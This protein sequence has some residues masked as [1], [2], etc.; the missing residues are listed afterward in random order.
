MS[1]AGNKGT[2]DKKTTPCAVLAVILSDPERSEGESKNLLLDIYR[3]DGRPQVPAVVVSHPVRD[4]TA[5]RMGH[6]AF[7]PGLQTA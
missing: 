5:K 1:E 7:L 2:T 6:L 4:E 3:E